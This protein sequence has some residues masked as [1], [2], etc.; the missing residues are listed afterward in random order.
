MMAW[1]VWK[2]LILD[3]STRQEPRRMDT[4]HDR[5]CYKSRGYN[6]SMASPKE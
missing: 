2:N 6:S 4:V 5:C 3:I 1:T